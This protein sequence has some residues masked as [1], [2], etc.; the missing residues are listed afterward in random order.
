MIDENAKTVSVII[1]P[2]GGFDESEAEYLATLH[3]KPVSLGKRIL[4]CETAAVYALS[5]ISYLLEK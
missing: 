4:R 5:V 2:E 1:G 3:F